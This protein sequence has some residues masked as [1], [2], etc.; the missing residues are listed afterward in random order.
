M[1]TVVLDF[2]FKTM[3]EGW[4]KLRDGLPSLPERLVLRQVR[5]LDPGLRKLPDA[6]RDL[7][8][9]RDVLMRAAL[10][11]TVTCY[12]ADGGLTEH[13]AVATDPLIAPDMGYADTPLIVGEAPPPGAECT[14]AIEFASPR[15][16]LVAL[17]ADGK[18]FVIIGGE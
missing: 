11:E 6:V 15:A 2:E 1:Q 18:A 7:P 3:A 4:P 5:S 9:P 13:V 12:G 17:A 14:R 10:V 16:A 8:V